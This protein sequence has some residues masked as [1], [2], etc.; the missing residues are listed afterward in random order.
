MRIIKR[1]SISEDKLW[2]QCDKGL[3]ECQIKGEWVLID[4]GDLMD[5]GC[6]FM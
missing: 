5:V 2:T 1:V 6:V 4:R 3:R